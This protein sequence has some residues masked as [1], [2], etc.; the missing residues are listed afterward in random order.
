[1]KI[2]S[3]T[4]D[5]PVLFRGK[6][7]SI[8]E[9]RAPE[10]NYYI[11][12]IAFNR[13][14]CYFITIEFNK[15]QYV[16]D[17]NLKHIKDKKTFKRINLLGSLLH[18]RVNVVEVLYLENKHSCN[19]VYTYEPIVTDNSS[20]KEILLYKFPYLNFAMQENKLLFEEY[21]SYMTTIRPWV[22]S[23][24]KEYLVVVN[25]Q[26]KKYVLAKFKNKLKAEHFINEMNLTDAS[27]VHVV[28]NDN[29]QYSAV[30]D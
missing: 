12:S 19:V 24:V 30:D 25:H 9:V 20:L 13:E 1:M 6:V 11:N 18:S 10:L 28:I 2:K 23:C 14:H 3:I 26:E 29:K 7:L 5:C 4:F 8:E 27:I 15:E 22:R 16:I 21:N 17:S